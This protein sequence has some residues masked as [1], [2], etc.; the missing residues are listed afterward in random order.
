MQK[1]EY[2]VLAYDKDGHKHPQWNFEVK[3]VIH[4]GDK[5]TMLQLLD[6]Y[7]IDGWEAVST[8]SSEPTRIL[9]KR[10]VEVAPEYSEPRITSLG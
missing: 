6:K 8:V 10:P 2:A 5:A 4:H 7:G 9:L 1:W 3:D